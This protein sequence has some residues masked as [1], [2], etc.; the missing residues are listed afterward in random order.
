[1]K[2]VAVS[3]LALV[4]STTLAADWLHYRGPSHNGATLEKITAFPTDGPKELWRVQVGI[5]LSSVTVAGN[6]A[7]TAGY[8]DGQ[9]IVYCLDVATGKVVWSHGWVAKLRDNLFEGGPRATPTVSGERVYMV[10]NEGQVVCLDAASG[11]LAWEKN[12]VADFGGKRPEWGFSGAPTVDGANVLLDSG[13]AGASTIALHKLTGALAWKAGDD[14]AGYG[15]VILAE[16]GGKRTALVFKAKA[17]V[18]LD[19]STGAELWRQTWETN[20]DVNAASPVVAGDKVFLTSGYGKGATALRIT[21]GKPEQLW[22]NKS[23]R[24]H[25]NSPVVVGGFAYGMDGTAD[26]KAPLVCVD[27]ENGET[28]WK[29]KDVQ[30]GSLILAG[31]KLLIL[32]ETGD[33]VLADPSPSGYKEIS[34]KHVLGARN[35]VQP[36]LAN[37]RIFAR[38]NKGELVALGL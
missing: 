28:K 27:L 19:H 30:G 36:T 7:Y 25:F 10:G 29:S 33:I 32:T 24:A 34:R 15:P 21:A 4:A 37:G 11:K 35:W 6:R 9:E 2:I 3:A 18:A 16:L 17:L 23:L 8:K 12:L 13:G 5:G 26:P 31:D 20:Y 1:M 14:G 22:F 38:N